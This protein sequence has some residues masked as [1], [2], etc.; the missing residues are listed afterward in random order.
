MNKK[1]KLFNSNMNYCKSI[2][3]D[4]KKGALSMG[5]LKYNDIP[6]VSPF[7]GVPQTWNTHI[8]S[9]KIQ[10]K[11]LSISEPKFMAILPLHLY[12][13]SYSQTLSTLLFHAH[14]FFFKNNVLLYSS[15]QNKGITIGKILFYIH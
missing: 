1:T 2:S 11:K 7:S 12:L 3:F 6:R 10:N 13:K 9:N 14:S 4:F 15:L 5:K 8:H